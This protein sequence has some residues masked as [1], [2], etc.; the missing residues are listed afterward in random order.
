MVETDQSVAISL[1]EDLRGQ[2]ESLERRLF[3]VETG[4]LIAGSVAGLAGSYLLV[5][6]S[7]RVWDSPKWLRSAA[8]VGGAV[9]IGWFAS[10]WIKRWVI[11]RR[12]RKDLAA[13]VQRRFQRLG[14]RLL[15]IV[16]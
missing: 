6:A 3:R 5:F 9:T 1:P 15:G 13:I 2:F 10:G 12:T 8:F 7:D 4:V 14:D 11:K 16:E